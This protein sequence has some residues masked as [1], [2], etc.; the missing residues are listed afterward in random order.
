MKGA[1]IEMKWL[2]D[3][4][5][6]LDNS[7]SAVE[8]QQCA[9]AFILRWNNDVSHVGILNKLKDMRLLLDQQSNAELGWMLYSD[10]RIQEC[11]PTEFFINHNIWHV[12]V[13]LIVFVMVE[14]HESNRV[15]LN[16]LHKIDLR[17][18]T[19]EDCYKFMPNISI[20]GNIGMIFIPMCEPIVQLNLATSSDYMT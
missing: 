8:R 10:P 3:N 20:F 12:K 17:G 4:F 1:L 11:I 13:S 6:H 7:S 2:E 18:R 16:K 14:M 5:S 9:R 19:G 15:M